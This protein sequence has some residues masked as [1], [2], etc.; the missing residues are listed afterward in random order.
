MNIQ[1]WFPLALTGLVSLQPKGLSRVFSRI[2]V[3]NHQYFSAQPS[4][5][6]NSYICTWLL[7]QQ[8]IWLYRPLLAKCC[9]F[10][11]FFNMLFTFVTLSLPGSKRLLLSWLQWESALILDPK[12]IKSVTAST[13]S[14][15]ICHEVMRP[16]TMILAFLM[17]NFNPLFHSPL[18][19]SSK[20]SLASLRFLPLDWC[21]LPTWGCWYFSRQSWLQL[22]IHPAQHF[23]WCTLHIS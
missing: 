8:Y 1:D 22:V 12:K 17:L 11:F 18:L 13:F 6:I 14:S 20:S 19:P 4:L 15:Y 23:T 2:T 3:W 5:R 10:F 16:N 7:G 9:L 21:H